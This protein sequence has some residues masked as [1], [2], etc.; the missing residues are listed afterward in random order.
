MA[1]E[2][3]TIEQT[4]WI[5]AKP[6]QVYDS[7]VNETKHAEFTGARAT[8]E[9]IA[10]GKFTAWDGYITG[11]N[12]E[13]VRARR[14]VQEWQTTEWPQGYPPSRLEFTFREK[15][16][17]TEVTMFHSEVPSSQAKAY[18]QGWIDYYWTPLKE[19]FSKK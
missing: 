18:Q 15:D 8:C 1:L 6:V 19:Y 12:L 2:T 9:P 14:I 10:G 13:L 5:P 3:T 4:V 11:I 7:F 16:E 17:G